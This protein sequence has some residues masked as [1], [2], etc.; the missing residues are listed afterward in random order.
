VIGEAARFLQRL[1][2]V[3][4]KMEW[5]LSQ[6]CNRQALSVAACSG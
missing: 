2:L 1:W 6:F 3:G 5:V 4:A